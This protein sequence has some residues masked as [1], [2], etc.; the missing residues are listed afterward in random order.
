MHDRRQ[1]PP[2]ARPLPRRPQPRARKRTSWRP[3]LLM[4]GALTFGSVLALGAVA[5]VALLLMAT[6]DRVAA[7]VTVAG[8]DIGGS[9]EREAETLIADL[10]ARPIALVD[11]VRQWQVTPGEFG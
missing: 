1:P 4:G 2:P 10:A 6:P 11:G 8:Q 9:S 3:W 7:G 5:F